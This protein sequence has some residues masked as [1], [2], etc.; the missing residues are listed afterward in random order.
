[1]STSAHSIAHTL[2][3]DALA[4]AFIDRI[5]DDLLPVKEAARRAGRTP[6]RLGQ[7]IRDDRLPAI[8]ITLNGRGAYLV[9]QADLAEWCASV[10]GSEVA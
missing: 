1:M 9:R 2:P 6:E 10:R 5:G 7:I 3:T 8:H 4:A